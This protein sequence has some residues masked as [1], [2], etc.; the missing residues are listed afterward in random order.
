ME[1]LPIIN[2]QVRNSIKKLQY[3]EATKVALSIG[4]SLKGSKWAE[5]YKNSTKQSFWEILA[6]QTN[7][8]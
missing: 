5:Y 7:F 6:T 4:K 1:R 3:L 2:M 8:L